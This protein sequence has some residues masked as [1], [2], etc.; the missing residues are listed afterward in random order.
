MESLDLAK[1]VIWFAVFLFSTTAHEAAHAWAA[2]KMGDKTAHEGGQ[3]SLDPWPHVRREP[4]GMVLAPLLSFSLGGFMLGWAS[5]PYD[6]QWAD[7]HPRRAAGMSLAGPLANLS[8]VLLAGLAMHAGILAGI[9]ESPQ[10]MNFSHLVDSAQDGIMDG[11]ATILSVMFSLNLF[12]FGFNLMP[13]PPLDGSGAL[14]LLLGD[15]GARRL[16][17]FMAQ[18][19][20]QFIGIYIA[21]KGFGYV[22]GPLHSFA[23]SLLYPGMNYY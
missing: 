20:L 10:S 23:I 3:V 22:S 9:Y 5:T 2:F 16:Q 1:A 7:R 4:F 8:L 19:M 14:G 21:W 11:V 12:L 18:P 15:E 13:V 17:D 6:R